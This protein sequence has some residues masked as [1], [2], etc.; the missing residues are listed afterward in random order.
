MENI[1]T[2]KWIIT[3]AILLVILSVL[4]TSCKAKKITTTEYKT[5]TI[6]IT[7]IIKVTPKSLNEL[8]IESL[9]D[10]LGNLKPINYTNTQGKVKTII[11]TVNNTLYV[12][13]DTD[14]IR[15]IAVKEYKSS[16]TDKVQVTE[17]TKKYIPKWVWYVL[18]YSILASVW[19]FRKP[20]LKLIKPI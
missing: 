2:Q 13:V 11:K 16:I 14:S 12:E 20:L 7:K 18:I 8:V 3:I 9:C 4:L 17:I 6:K 19:I 5:D 10:S 1:N 15:E